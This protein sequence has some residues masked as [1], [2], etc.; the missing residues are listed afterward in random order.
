VRSYLILG[1]CTLFLIQYFAQIPALQY[2][3]VLVSLLA[4]LGSALKADRFPR[5]VGFIMMGIG[6]IIE[7]NKGTGLAGISDGIFLILPLLCLITLS[8]LLSIPMKLGGY[9]ESVS[10]VLHNL[11]HQPK[12]LF[13]GITGT[14]VL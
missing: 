10:R 12:K 5:V 8:P 2:V 1:M 13:I 4:F 9:F 3:V 6:I 14:F 7:W 11:L